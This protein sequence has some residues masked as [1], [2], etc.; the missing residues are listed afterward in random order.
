MT[1]QTNIL[2]SPSIIY[3]FKCVYKQM[4][5]DRPHTSSHKRS[6]SISV[7]KSQRTRRTGQSA[8]DLSATRSSTTTICL[9]QPE[10]AI[11]MRLPSMERNG[12]P[13]TPSLAVGQLSPS[14]CHHPK[15]QQRQSTRSLCGTD[16]HIRL[17]QR[18]P[19]RSP[20]W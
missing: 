19:E 10:P 8:D 7:A 12:Q 14:T 15:H 17:T 9:H 5:I 20:L 16:N 13:R 4:R 11:H 3:P 1:H 18:Q 6:A 2:S